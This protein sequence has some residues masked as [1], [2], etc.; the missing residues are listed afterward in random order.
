MRLLLYEWCCSGGLRGP[1]A[2]AVVGNASPAGLITEGRLMLEALT[3]DAFQLVGCEVT[4]L[5]DGL[6]PAASA[7]R[8]PASVRR[9]KVAD[10]EELVALVDAARDADAVIL[11]APETAGVLSS[12]LSLLDAAGMGDRVVGGPLSFVVA[13]ARCMLMLALSTAGVCSRLA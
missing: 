13:A 2:A 11:V 4:I 6:L 9:R 7:P 5:S 8:F 12:R 3:N 10:G 1:D